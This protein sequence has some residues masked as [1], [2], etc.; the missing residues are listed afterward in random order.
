MLEYACKRKVVSESVMRGIAR[1]TYEALINAC[2]DEGT[3][4]VLVHLATREITH[5]NMFMK[6]LDQMGKLHDAL[7]GNIEPDETVKLVFNLSQATMRAAP[8]MKSLIS[9]KSQILNPKAACRPHRSIRMTSVRRRARP[10]RRAKL[11]RWRKDDKKVGLRR[12]GGSSP[13]RLSLWSWPA[14][15]AP[16]V[17]SAGPIARMISGAAS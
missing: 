4:K 17:E 2:E 16:I 9:N 6:A 7:F 10:S 15:S 1:Q 14:H 12:R 8:G 13:P 3:K 5:A 11:G